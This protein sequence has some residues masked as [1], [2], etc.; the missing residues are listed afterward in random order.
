MNLT[1]ALTVFAAML[2]GPI[3]DGTVTVSELPPVQ[4]AQNERVVQPSPLPTSHN[5]S[6]RIAAFWIVLPD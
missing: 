2:T 5:P 4:I 1:A 6:R 3:P